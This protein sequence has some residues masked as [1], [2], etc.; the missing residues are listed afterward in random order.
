MC[1]AW[2]L[3]VAKARMCEPYGPDLAGKLASAEEDFLDQLDGRL[4]AA[5]HSL[6]SEDAEAAPA[7]LL[8]DWG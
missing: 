6:K 5:M 3:L 7:C 8:N 1:S 4:T 2:C